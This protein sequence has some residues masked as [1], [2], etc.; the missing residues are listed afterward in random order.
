[1]NKFYIDFEGY[2][3]IEA[4]NYSHA[5]SKFFELLEQKEIFPKAYCRIMGVEEKTVDNS[6]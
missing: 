4:E 5:Q 1:M 2:C 6:Q 3:E